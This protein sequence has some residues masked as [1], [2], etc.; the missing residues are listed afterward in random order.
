LHTHQELILVKSI[1]IAAA[2][3]AIAVPAFAEGV[4][5]ATPT[6]TANSGAILAGGAVWACDK[7]VCHTTS[8][9]STAD[10]M[11]SCRALVKEIG[12][13]T[14]FSTDGHAYSAGRLATC[15]ASAKT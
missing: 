9:T 2:L 14:A 4:W 6:K 1:F 12:P 3:A 15:N 11:T 5:T 13:V 8:D 10:A 7:D